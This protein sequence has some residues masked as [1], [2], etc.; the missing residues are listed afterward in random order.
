MGLRVGRFVGLSLKKIRESIAFQHYLNVV[1]NFANNSTHCGVLRGRTGLGVGLG[2][3]WF[4]GLALQNEQQQFINC[5]SRSIQLLVLG[6]ENL[7]GSGTRSWP[8]SGMV[9]WS[10]NNNAKAAIHQLKLDYAIDNYNWLC[11]AS[12][13]YRGVGRGVGL[14]VG[15]FVGLQVKDKNYECYYLSAELIKTAVEPNV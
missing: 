1:V 11:S 14:G 10:S 12:N 4:V 2:V 3:G 6:P 7:P 5:I 15:W 8:R 13:S 9:S